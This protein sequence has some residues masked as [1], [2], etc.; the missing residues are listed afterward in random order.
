MTIVC[1]LLSMT[2]CSLVDRLPGEDSLYHSLPGS[3]FILHREITIRPGQLR[4]S[5][6]DGTPAYG[7]SEFYPHCDLVLPVISKEPQIIPA[8]RYRIGSVMGRTHYVERPQ[9]PVQLAAADGVNGLL[10]DSSSEWYMFAYHMSLQSET[11][12]TRLQLICG[13]AYNYP[14]YVR[15]PSLAEIQQ[16]LGDYGTLKLP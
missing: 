15:Y 5:F 16:S 2:A 14:Y 1:C 4:M 7:Y 6:Q 12:A 8:G 9:G 3:E 10:A 11:S 13:G